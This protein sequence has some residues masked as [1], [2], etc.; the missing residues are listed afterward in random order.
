MAGTFTNAQAALVLAQGAIDTAADEAALTKAWDEYLTLETTGALFDDGKGGKTAAELTDALDFIEQAYV[1]GRTGYAVLAEAN[2]VLW[3]S[4]RGA[5]IDKNGPATSDQAADRIIADK[6]TGISLLRAGEQLIEA[7][8]NIH[9]Q[10][11]D[12]LGEDHPV[13]QHFSRTIRHARET[14]RMEAHQEGLALY[15]WL[16]DRLGVKSKAQ[17][18]NG[19]WRT[20]CFWPRRRAG[21]RRR[22]VNTTRIGRRCMP[23]PTL[24]GELMRGI[25]GPR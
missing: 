19:R 18:Q 22:S 17:P 6:R 1:K 4:W 15:Q 13:T 2:K 20:S 7:Q 9:Q 23:V 16:R 14:A 11:I 3:D 10:L 25:L 5:V 8:F 21:Q 24:M 12:L